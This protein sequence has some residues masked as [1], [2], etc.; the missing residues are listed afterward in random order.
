[1]VEKSRRGPNRVTFAHLSWVHTTPSAV[2]HAT[3]KT[4]AR[5]FL[6]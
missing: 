3:E 4:L 1:M 6:S 2:A 5:S